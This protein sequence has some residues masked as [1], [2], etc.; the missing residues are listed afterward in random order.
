MTAV[1]IV[2][3]Y[4]HP[5]PAANSAIIT[6]L[7]H[8]LAAVGHRITV[9][10]AFPHYDTNRIWPAYRGR[11]L[12]RESLSGVDVYR[13]W[14][15]VPAH[16]ASMPGRLLS[17]LSFN[18]LST[19]VGLTVPR[20]DVIL[21]PS[22]PLTIGLSAW[23]LGLLRRAPYVY[24]VQDIYPDIAVR[25]GT[26]RDPRLIAFFSWLERFIYARASA[27]AVISEGFRQNLL[28]KGVP[29]GKI[30]L[31]PNSV[32]VDF[33]TPR[34]KDNPFA[35]RKGLVERFVLLYA[36]NVG[37]SQGLEQVLAAARILSERKDLLFLIV[38]NGSAKAALEQEAV[39]LGLHNVRFLPFQPREVV[40]DLYASADVCLVPLRKGVG[41]ESLPSKA[42]TIMAAGRPVVASVD[43]GSDAWTLVEE[44]RCGLCTPPEDPQALAGAIRT[45]HA[46][47]ALRQRLGRNGRAH[48]TQHYTPQAVARQY[49]ALL[50]RV[51]RSGR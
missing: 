11:L 9:I 44:A 36:G 39:A 31:I 20:P 35:R 4:H 47:P 17:Y 1:A 19:L 38:G 28:R 29:A 21:A 24:N 12:Q 27:V 10:S 15:Y 5:D 51:A 18:L 45:L 30:A 37:L 26:L 42:L 25:L 46:D 2:S 8:D 22:P 33:V 48:V 32:D 49:D 40:P 23:L 6:R 7:A 43:P 50:T 16:K 3:L 14:L 34:V 41:Y 13:V